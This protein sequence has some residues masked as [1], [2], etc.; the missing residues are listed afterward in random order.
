MGPMAGSPS[1]ATSIEQVAARPAR[2]GTPRTPRAAA[3]S[4]ISPP[5]EARA[6]FTA[7]Q[8]TRTFYLRD[9]RFSAGLRL[10]QRAALGLPA[11]DEAPHASA[12]AR[13]FM[14]SL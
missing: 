9:V 1:L 4:R 10:Q 12:R 14:N 3:R 7:S 5:R 13:I 6:S 2:R 8:R 11:A